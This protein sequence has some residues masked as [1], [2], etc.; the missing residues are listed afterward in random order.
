MGELA[1]VADR[2]GCSAD[3]GGCGWDGYGDV[4]IGPEGSCPS[5]SRLAATIWDMRAQAER[6][7]Q[8]VH[9]G[10]ASPAI[11]EE[12]EAAIAQKNESLAGASMRIED[13]TTRMRQIGR[14]LDREEELLSELRAIRAQLQE[15]LVEVRASTPSP[16]LSVSTIVEALGPCLPP[17]EEWQ[18]IAPAWAAFVVRVKYD[19]A[20]AAPASSSDF[21]FRAGDAG[22]RVRF[23]VGTDDNG[24]VRHTIAVERLLL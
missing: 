17:G 21:E 16:D 8:E 19:R 3:P 6:L 22:V 4:A 23:T 12:L 2:K 13:V 7:Q 9:A 24:V 11:V 10:T 1:N 14:E 20:V 15:L 18:R 5:Y